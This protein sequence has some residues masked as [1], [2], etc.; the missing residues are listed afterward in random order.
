MEK[1]YQNGFFYSNI[2]TFFALKNNLPFYSLRL[3]KLYKYR[4]KDDL[5]ILLQNAVLNLRIRS[6]IRI[7]SF[8]EMQDPDP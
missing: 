5:R 8:L 4:I 2:L 1:F 7:L 6:R 3:P